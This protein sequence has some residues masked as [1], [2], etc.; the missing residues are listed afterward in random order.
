MASPQK[1]TE[2]SKWADD[3]VDQVGRGIITK[4]NNF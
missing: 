3:R 2:D 4:V 1:S